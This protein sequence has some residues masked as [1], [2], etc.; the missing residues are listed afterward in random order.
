[1]VLKT[2]VKQAAKYWPR[3]ERLDT[4]IDYVNTEGGEGINF[5]RERTPERDVSP[6]TAETLQT[7]TDLLIQLNKTWEDDLL[8]LC[9]NLFRRQISEP[10]VLTEVEAVKALDFLRKKAAA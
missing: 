6:A 3:R 1:M 9:S 8:P 4:A 5:N 7:I 2:V 10:S